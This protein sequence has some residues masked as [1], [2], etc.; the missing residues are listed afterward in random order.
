MN[1]ESCSVALKA[2]ALDFERP[3]PGLLSF[4]ETGNAFFFGRNQE[5]A[6][7]HRRVKNHTLTTL[8]GQ[9]GYGKTSLV[10]AG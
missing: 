7:L 1:N 8:F 6:E 9:S 10:L 5:I 3:W 2:S 4:T